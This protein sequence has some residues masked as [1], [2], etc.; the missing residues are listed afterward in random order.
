MIGGLETWWP[1][2]ILQ[3][4]LQV[5]GRFNVFFFSCI[6]HTQPAS[7]L[8][9]LHV[10]LNSVVND[11]G[12][13]TPLTGCPYHVTQWHEKYSLAHD[14]RFKYILCG[15]VFSGIQVS[16]AFSHP[17]QLS[18]FVSLATYEGTYLWHSFQAWHSV[19]FGWFCEHRQTCS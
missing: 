3:N 11:T 13:F 17:Y 5:N 9:E 16:S 19:M 7:V 18:L 10:I 15:A 8:S 1:R 12:L 4:H 6:K 2:M 14:P